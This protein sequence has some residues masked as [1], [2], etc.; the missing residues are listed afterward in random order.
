MVRRTDFNSVEGGRL[1]LAQEVEQTLENAKTFRPP[2]LPAAE[3]LPEMA[4]KPLPLTDSQKRH[5]LDAKEDK[6]PADVEKDS[7]YAKLEEL[8]RRVL[9]QNLSEMA[10]L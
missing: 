10:S 8:I 1:E 6:V 5:K 3:L 2:P 9:K 7:K 4:Y